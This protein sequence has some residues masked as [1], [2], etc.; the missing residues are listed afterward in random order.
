MIEFSAYP[1]FTEDEMRCRCGCGR[2]DMDPQF[3]RTLERIR[4]GFGRPLKITSGFRCPEYDARPFV[5]GAGVHPTGR[6]G[7]IGIWGEDVFHLLALVYAD[8]TI[9]GIGQKQHGP[10]AGRFI[11]LD[12]THGPLRPRIWTYP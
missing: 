1:N 4:D 11:H 6:A 3:M 2:A 7:D 5:G 8:G 9:T 12:T 10:H